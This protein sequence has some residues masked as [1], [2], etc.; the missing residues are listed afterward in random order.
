MD[1]A[2]LNGDYWSG[3]EQGIN[4][5]FIAGGPDEKFKAT[6]IEIYGVKQAINNFY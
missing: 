4:I 1:Q 2:S 6:A 3:I 5:K